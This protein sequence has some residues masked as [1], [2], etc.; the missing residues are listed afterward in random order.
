MGGQKRRKGPAWLHSGLREGRSPKPGWNSCRDPK[1]TTTGTQT[2]LLPGT[3][4]Q[5]PLCPPACCPRLLLPSV[6]PWTAFPCTQDRTKDQAPDCSPAS[7]LGP[8]PAPAPVQHGQRLRRA[9]LS[10]GMEPGCKVDTVRCVKGTE[11]GTGREFFR[12]IYMAQ[13]YWIKDELASI[14]AHDF[15]RLA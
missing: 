7:H 8:P 10:A 13:N 2:A 11:N 6:N 5:H 14:S 3:G 1:T 15:L 9:L 12:D 4:D